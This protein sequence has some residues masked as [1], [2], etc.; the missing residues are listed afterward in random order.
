MAQWKRLVTCCRQRY[1]CCLAFLLRHTAPSRDASVV[2]D[3]L[4]FHSHSC[5]DLSQP[6]PFRIK[7][8]AGVFLFHQGVRDCFLF[9]LSGGPFMALTVS[10]GERVTSVCTKLSPSLLVAKHLL[11]ALGWAAAS[12]L[13]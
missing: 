1:R 6:F 12:S 11:I 13:L 9:Q 7:I 8:L 10:M 5:Q 2:R 4:G 3:F